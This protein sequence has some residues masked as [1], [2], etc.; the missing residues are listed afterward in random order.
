MASSIE[1]IQANIEGATA[2]GFRERLLA[3]GQARSMIWRDGELPPDAPPFSELL[4][5]DL[6]SY[7]YALLSHGLRLLELQ[8]NGDTARRA[9]EHAG[10]ALEAVVSKGKEDAD[11]DFHRL[12]AAAAYH[13]GRFSARSYSLLHV[14]IDKANLTRGERCLALL[15]LRDLTS[16]HDELAAWRTQGLGSDDTLLAEL[17]RLEDAHNSEAD[18]VESE[19]IGA[20]DSALTDRYLGSLATALLA[21][22]R[23]ESSLIDTALATLR[24]GVT[25]AAETSLVSQWWCHRL[26]IHLLDGLWDTSLH[27]RLPLAGPGGSAPKEW[28]DLRAMFVAT[29]FRRDRAEIELWPSQLDAAQRALEFESNLVLALPTSAGK[30]RIAELCILACLAAGKRVVFVTPLRALSAQTEVALQRTFQPL[31]KAV[32]TLYG[33]IGASDADIDALTRRDIIVATPEKLDFALRSDP[34]LF[35]DVGLVVL[36]EGHMIGMTERE[37]RYEAQIQ[38]LL[39][40]ADS[41]SRR[42][43]CLSAILPEGEQLKDFVDWLTQDKSDGLIKRPWRPTRLRFGEVTWSKD[44]GRLTVSIGDEQPYVPRFLNAVKPP[45]GLR[46]EPF[47][48]NQRE[49]CL[50]TAWRLVAEGH[51]VLIFCPQRRSVEPFAKAVVDLHGRG[52]LPSVFDGD[53]K[54]LDAALTI[55]AEWLGPDHVALR[56]LKLGVAIHHGTL[57]TPYRKEVERLLRAGTLRVTISSPTLAQGLNLSATSLIFHALAR[58]RDTIEISEFKN[59]VGRAGRAYIDMEGLVLYPMFDDIGKRRSEWQSLVASEAGRQ[60]ESG[61]LR[62]VYTL[63][64]RMSKKLATNDVNKLL[65]Y[66]GGV[67]AWDF[68]SIPAEPHATTAIEAANWR[69][70]MT[71][72]DTAILSLLGDQAVPDE[73]VEKRLDAALASSLFTRRLKHLGAPTQKVL[74]GTLAARARYVWSST[75]VAQR[76]GYFFAGVGYETGKALDAQASEL[77][78]LLVHA[79]AALLTQD[80]EAA[81]DA[82]VAF[83]KIIFTISPFAPT[84]IPRDW[85][86]VL[87]VWLSGA[88]LSDLVASI[89]DEALRFVEE[90]LIYRLPWGMEAVRVR[91]LAHDN[92]DTFGVHLTSFELGLA[93]PAVETGTTNRSA[94]YLIQ[95]GFSSRLAAIKAVSDGKGTFTTSSELREWIAHKELKELAADKLWPTPETHELWHEFVRS[96]DVRAARRWKR[97]SVTVDV[98]WDKGIAPQPGTALRVVSATPVDV[99][100]AADFTRLGTVK[101]RL[102]PK[103]NGSLIAT[104][105]STKSVIDLEYLGPDRLFAES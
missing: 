99:V 105:S 76:R 71:S 30:T 101:R 55:G 29:L 59:V 23:G 3:R 45:K 70:Y 93:L 13:L 41:D 10:D 5:Y 19:L 57:P 58:D 67:A 47:P 82:L 12:V 14:S 16:L 37:V 74:K 69:S 86:S 39:R 97:T 66:V 85:E 95:S 20:I 53:K 43:V 77:E 81:T 46:K 9:F 8:G 72:L 17:G 78:A 64:L 18:D 28:P 26:A 51:T 31:G 32:S 21:L 87:R 102:N 7:G 96:F 38:R 61:L 94:A 73:E 56:C 1:E 54:L 49:L 63:L 6:L 80:P 91:A 2:A 79:N 22:E 103:R 27:R 89:G 62:L 35:D 98:S 88:P 84:H 33:S 50:A 48:R 40:R 42:I 15:M 68:P 34:A 104:A 92:V 4:T 100:T 83:A 11:R 75:T 44:H 52:L 36:D 65:E 25:A 90:G 60:M 24:T